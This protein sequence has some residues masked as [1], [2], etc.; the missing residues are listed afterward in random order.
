MKNKTNSEAEVGEEVWRIIHHKEG[1]QILFKIDST[2]TLLYYRS[3][4][5][6][7]V[8]VT[9]EETVTSCCPLG[10][11]LSGEGRQEKKPFILITQPLFFFIFNHMCASYNQK[12]TLIF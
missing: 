10:S 11:R 8:V 2:S 5:S 9:T 12:E 7:V 1:Q 6:K 3:I 4:V